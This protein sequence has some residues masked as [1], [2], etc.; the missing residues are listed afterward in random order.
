MAGEETLLRYLK[1]QRT[2]THACAVEIRHACRVYT[3][4]ERQT[5]GVHGRTDGRT[6]AW[7]HNHARTDRP[8][9][10]GRTN[11]RTDGRTYGRTDVLEDGQTDRWMDGHMHAQT[12]ACTHACTH[13]HM[14][15][16]THVHMYAH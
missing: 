9:M 8:D 12:H 13:T 15:A 1:K 16:R 3:L 11:G 7:M 10:E 4:R 14:H 5:G 6:H 2:G